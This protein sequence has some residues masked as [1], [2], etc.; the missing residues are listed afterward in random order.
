M[1]SRCRL[2]SPKTRKIALLAETRR[3]IV[4]GRKRLVQ[5]LSDALKQYRRRAQ[6]L[7][8]HQI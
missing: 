3:H 2:D 5:R 4:E 1:V 6:R 8:L 7:A